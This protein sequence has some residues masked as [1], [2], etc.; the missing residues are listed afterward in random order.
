MKQFCSILLLFLS[1]NLSAQFTD[2]INSN[3]PGQSDTPYAVGKGIHQ[4][5]AG[6][7]FADNNNIVLQSTFETKTLE[8]LFRTGVLLERLEVDFRANYKNEQQR[9]IKDDAFNSKT[10]QGLSD[11]GI[12]VKFMI[13]EQKYQDKSQQIRSWKKRT[14]FDRRRLIPTVGIY[15]GLNANMVS[16]PFKDEFNHSTFKAAILLQNNLSSRFV[17]LNNLVIDKIAQENEYFKHT[18]SGTFAISTTFSTYIESV[19]QY[20]VDAKPF[21]DHGFGFA[22]LISPDLQVETSFRSNL[23]ENYDDFLVSVG[24]AWRLQD[25]ITRWKNN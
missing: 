8:F 14:S 23:A 19:G 24:V 18:I 13:Y 15:T 20:S 16:N 3:R 21:F 22:Y 9:I 11:V 4:F 12:G 25:R 17:L 6:I 7:S 10:I 1:A 2:I 5:E